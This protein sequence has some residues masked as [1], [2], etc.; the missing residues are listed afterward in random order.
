[1]KKL[2]TIFVLSIINIAPTFAENWSR[3]G[4]TNSLVIY[5]D[6]ESWVKG[7][8]Y[9]TINILYDLKQPFVDNEGTANSIKYIRKFNCKNMSFSDVTAYFYKEKM[10]QEPLYENSDN[11][12]W[13]KINEFGS[14]DGSLF[15]AAC[16]M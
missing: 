16:Q 4:E 9:T 13:I 2:I 11:K 15:K 14:L 8:L 12:E 5:Y 10:G 1:M 7:D 6:K 3:Y